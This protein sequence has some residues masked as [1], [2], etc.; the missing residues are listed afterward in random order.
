ML[1]FARG[2]DLTCVV[3]FGT[4]PVGLPTGQAGAGALLLASAP[5]TARGELPGESAA[6][7]A[8][9]PGT[10]YVDASA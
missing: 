9:T 4:S 7:I 3:N 1:A 8:G 6:W 5:V 2:T 10:S